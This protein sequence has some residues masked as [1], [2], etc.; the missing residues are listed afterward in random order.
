MEHHDIVALCDQVT[1]KELSDE[2]RP[3][4]DESFHFG[5]LL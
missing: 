3:T 4:D 1:D 2:S 5:R